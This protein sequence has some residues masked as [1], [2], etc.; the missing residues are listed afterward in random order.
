MG[1]CEAQ[2]ESREKFA[3]FRRRN[4]CLQS[5]KTYVCLGGRT[6]RLSGKTY[7]GRVTGS[8]VG[9]MPCAQGSM[10]LG[11]ELGSG[12]ALCLGFGGRPLKDPA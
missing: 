1:A 2:F 5:C 10:G 11:G 6:H 3:C 9:V 4:A 8:S 12:C 7:L